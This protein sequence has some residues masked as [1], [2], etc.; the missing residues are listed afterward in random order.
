MIQVDLEDIEYLRGLR[1]SWVKIA[2]YLEISRSTLYR[3]MEQEGLSQY[4]K[5]TDICDADL[6]RVLLAIKQNYPNDGE[7]LV[8]GHLAAQ[9]II[10]PRA[11]LRASIHRIDPVNTALRRSVTIRRRVYNVPGPNV[12]WHIDGNHKLIK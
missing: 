3:R 9:G 12:V 6:D 1:L 8:A 7:R 11:K 5:Y 10:I 4:T 2:Q